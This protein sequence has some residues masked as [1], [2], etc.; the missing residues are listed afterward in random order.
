VDIQGYKCLPKNAEN[1]PLRYIVSFNPPLIV[2]NNNF[3]NLEISDLNTR[4]TLI[5]LQPKYE[6][7]YYSLFIRKNAMLNRMDTS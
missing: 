4:E 5:Y 1:R 7:N 3:S 6:I 2:T